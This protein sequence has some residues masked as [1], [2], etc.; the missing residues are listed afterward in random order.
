MTYG[1]KN[2]VYYMINFFF[3]DLYKA[4]SQPFLLAHTLSLNLFCKSSSAQLHCNLN[5]NGYLNQEVIESHN[6]YNTKQNFFIFFYYKNR[7]LRRQT[8]QSSIRD[9]IREQNLKSFFFVNNFDIESL[10]ICCIERINRLCV[11]CPLLSFLK[12]EIYLKKNN[13]NNFT[14]LYSD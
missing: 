3:D 10:S 7:K 14:A 6:I 12:E 1:V 4:R 13:Q 5:Q 9:V 2:L 11:A 8:R